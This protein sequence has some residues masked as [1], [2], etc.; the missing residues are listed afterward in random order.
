M[1]IDPIKISARLVLKHKTKAE[2]DSENNDYVPDN[3]ELI[4]YS[5]TEKIKIGDGQTAPQHLKHINPTYTLEY[6][7]SNGAARISLMADDNEVGSIEINKFIQGGFLTEVYYDETNGNIV[8]RW[9]VNGNIEETLI[10][11]TNI[12][13]AEWRNKVN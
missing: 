11:L 13:P 12:L 8:F 6:K 5:D 1:A 3:S 7:D 2:W 4:V 9:N 10:P